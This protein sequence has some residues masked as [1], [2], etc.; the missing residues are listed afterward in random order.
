MDPVPT[1]S[2][3]MVRDLVTVS[4][5]A[6]IDDIARTMLEHNVDR[7]L[8]GHDQAIVGI[9]TYADILRVIANGHLTYPGMVRH[10]GYSRGDFR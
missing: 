6:T 1:A 9:L 2:D 5:E 3:L 8:V 10:T 7:V 4:P